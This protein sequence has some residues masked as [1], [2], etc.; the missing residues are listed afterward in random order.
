MKYAYLYLIIMV[1]LT[2]CQQ[3]K[4]RKNQ[5]KIERSDAFELIR[6][7]QYNIA[8]GIPSAGSRMEYY[9]TILIK[10]TMGLK[11]DSIWSDQGR[12]ALFVSRKK[13]EI[14]AEKEPIFKGDT[15][16]VRASYRIPETKRETA[17]PFKHAGKVLLSYDYRSKKHYYSIQ[18]LEQRTGSKPN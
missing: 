17:L 2:A 13:M 8:G 18:N 11:F 16:T 6:A 14:S 1:F 9:F 10:D 12:F 15:L 5:K 3:G 7:E 4:I